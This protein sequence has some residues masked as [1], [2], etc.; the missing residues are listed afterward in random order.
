M[1]S[2]E[3]TA[4]PPPQL[5]TLC[6]SPS[7][8]P[9]TLISR[10]WFRF[11]HLACTPSCL[12]F[13]P[14]HVIQPFPLSCLLPFPPI[15]HPLQGVLWICLSSGT[16]GFPETTVPLSS[17]ISHSPDLP[18]LW[19]GRFSENNCSSLFMGSLIQEFVLQENFSLVCVAWFGQRR[20]PLVVVLP[21]LSIEQSPDPR[22]IFC[23]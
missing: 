1:P 18:V 5:R 7:S 21:P 9:S 14:N 8:P 2:P 17:C 11:F 20:W 16:G 12:F 6:H 10:P 19:Y 3:P 15:L 22:E 13:R 23:S 4:L